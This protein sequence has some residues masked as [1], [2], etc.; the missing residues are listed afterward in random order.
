MSLQHPTFQ[1]L[2]QGSGCR[3]Q[4]PLHLIL[5]IAAAAVATLGAA[6]LLPLPLRRLPR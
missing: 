5:L 1:R 4:R 6:M 2:L 3:R